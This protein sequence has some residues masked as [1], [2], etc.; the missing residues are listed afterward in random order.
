MRLVQE[1]EARDPSI[2]QELW[3][4]PASFVLLPDKLPA[5]GD[6]VAGY[7]EQVPDELR[8]GC[9]ALLTSGSTG[10]PKLVVARKDRAEALARTLHTAQ[11]SE[12]A[13]T[14]VVALPI[15]YTFAFVNQVVWSLTH[16]RGLVLTPGLA[17]PDALGA[18]LAAAPDAL[19]CLVSAQLPLLSRAFCGRTFPGVVRLHFAG[20]RFPQE[21]LGAVRAMFPRAAIFNNYGCAEA[22]PRLTLRPAEA[23]DDGAVVGPP[24][25]GVELDVDDAGAL[26]FRSAYRA[27]AV[28]DESGLER[29]G[30]DAWLPTGDLAELLPDGSC[31]LLGRS[32]EVFKR[33][34]EKVSLPI[35]RRALAEVWAGELAFYRET[36]KYGEQGHVLVLAPAPDS[37]QV[38]ALL[39][40]LR[41]G[42][43]RPHWPLRIESVTA[44]PLSHA[45]KIDTAALAATEEKTIQ[46]IQRL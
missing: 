8:S 40:H 21:Q 19:L 32:S 34:G 43:A 1:R 25:P 7:L 39:Q 33:F 9:F 18:A 27:V 5:G 38:Q 16:G 41:K 14:A 2:L 29:I 31:R 10:L 3:R 13:R 17:D 35:L 28:V 37:A 15:S 30:D 22:M 44:M 42:F 4:A 6:F 45:N 20:G 23:D 26:R 36:D 12:A 46:W 11:Q 24:L